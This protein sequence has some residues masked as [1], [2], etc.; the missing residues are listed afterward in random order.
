MKCAPTVSTLYRDKRAFAYYKEALLNY[1]YHKKISRLKV[2]SAPCAQGEEVYT[3]AAI[4]TAYGLDSEVLGVDISE[5]NLE[6]ALKG[7]Y[8]VSYK[9]LTQIPT[10]YLSKGFFEVVDSENDFVYKIRIP[11]SLKSKTKFMQGNLLQSFDYGR[12]D[13]V[14]CMNF[15]YHID[16]GDLRLQVLENLSNNLK[17]GGLLFIGGI[18]KN[19]DEVIEDL[20]NLSKFNLYRV[21][22]V[23]NVFIKQANA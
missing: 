5:S 21:S 22:R 11:D 7:E 23:S 12:F 10:N 20:E 17:E 18:L 2:L 4:T 8:L 13:V 9:T 15:I 3:I 6:K 16:D 14:F 1:F 19:H